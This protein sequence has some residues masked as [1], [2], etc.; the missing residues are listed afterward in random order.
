[1]PAEPEQSSDH[2]DA[3]PT[4]EVARIIFH[5]DTWMGVSEVGGHQVLTVSSG[6]SPPGDNATANITRILADELDGLVHT[7]AGPDFGVA[8]VEL[9]PSGSIEVVAVIVATYLV[10][11]QGVEV[12]ETL[13]K[14]AEL[15][16]FVVRA[17]MG[18]PPISAG[19][20]HARVD[21]NPTAAAVG[22]TVDAPAAPAAARTTD[23]PAA[24]PNRAA[25]FTSPAN[26]GS[27]LLLAVSNLLI[28][29]AVLAV[30][31]TH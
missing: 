12:L 18:S 31:L 8:Q 16:R 21:L 11:K 30:V 17:V 20:V 14:V 25:R 13:Q 5:V 24:S 23:V 9:R 4:I 15:G 1:M 3:H 6:A 26:L 22:R 10:V 2:Q 29:G 27:L 28:A 19:P 7:S